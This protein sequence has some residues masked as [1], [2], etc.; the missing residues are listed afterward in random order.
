M[1]EELRKELI[2][3]IKANDSTYN[4]N[5]VNFKYYSDKDLLVLKERLVREL[6]EKD[7]SKPKRDNDGIKP[8]VS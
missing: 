5:A 3:F 7:N 8:Q 1:T 4:Y 6:E 2:E